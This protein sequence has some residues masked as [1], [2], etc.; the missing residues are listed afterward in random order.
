MFFDWLLLTVAS[1]GFSGVRL[2]MAIQIRESRLLRGAV[3]VLKG[4][5]R[6]GCFLLASMAPFLNGIFSI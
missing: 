3:L 4:C 2:S 6:V 1:F 5:L